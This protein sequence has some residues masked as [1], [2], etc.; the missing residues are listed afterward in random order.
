M[1]GRPMSDPAPTERFSP[2]RHPGFLLYATGRLLLVSAGQIMSVAIG[3]QVYEMT[4]ST[5]HL[6]Y[7]GLAQFLP[8]LVFAFLSGPVADRFDRRKIVLACIASSLG[9]AL[10]L[11]R[12]SSSLA[13]IYAVAAAFG[14]IRSFSAPAGSALVGQLVP[15][16][17]L[18][19]AVAWQMTAF[20]A[21]MLG[22]PALGGFVYAAGGA[23]RVYLMAGAFYVGAL[24]TYALMRP[25]RAELHSGE[26][27]VRALGE[28]LRYV[29]KEKI[30]LGAMSLDLL[31]VLLGGATALLPVFARDIL[32]EGPDALGLL[33]SAPAVGAGLAAL[34]LALRPLRRRVGTKLLVS[35]AIFGLA[36]VGFGLS[37]GLPTALLALAVLGATDMVSVVVR[38]TLIQSCTPEGMRGRVSAVAFV[39]IGASNELGEF[40]SGLTA[41]WWGTV[42]AILVG[43]AGSIV[44]VALWA[45]LF[46]RLRR[47]DRFDS[48]PS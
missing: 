3:W 32:R 22:G 26:P 17:H 15:R 43:G 21:A 41:A 13:S 45:L 1:M 46:P 23:S 8:S 7:V 19:A 5:L 10:I 24:L 20:Q 35:V 28:G 9:A 31:A 2:L 37:R 48:G 34:F 6:G 33:R 27:L 42:P 36:T 39:F 25:R 29:W 18:G 30:L 40:E 12:Y 14:V 47:A 11:A 16:E 4:R 44:V 38:H